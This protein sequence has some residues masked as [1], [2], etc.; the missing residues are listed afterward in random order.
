MSKNNTQNLRRFNQKLQAMP[1]EI[2]RIVAARAAS[3]ITQRAQSSYDSGVSVYGDARENN[4]TLYQT[5]A[6]RDYVVFTSDGGTKIR[7]SL[8]TPY[9]K[10]LIGKYK[11]LPVGNAAMPWQWLKAIKEISL[12][13]MA[14]FVD[15]AKRAA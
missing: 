12:Q 14:L 5:G 6:T 7:A 2:A 3:A 11:I 8:G 10:Y 13:E 9:A 4:V 15:K 1:T